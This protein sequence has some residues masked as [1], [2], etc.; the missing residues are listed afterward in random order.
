MKSKMHNLYV[1]INN[2][3]WDHFSFPKTK[4]NE[5]NIAHT[6]ISNSCISQYWFWVI[7]DCNLIP[8]FEI[9]RNNLFASLGQD[10]DRQSLSM[11]F[12]TKS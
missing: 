10:L 6:A 1:I 7:G 2:M 5:K 11:S 8:L 4:I 9:T 3:A 12:D